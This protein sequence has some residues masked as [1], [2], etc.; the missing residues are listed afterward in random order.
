MSPVP[1]PDR[2]QIRN[3]TERVYLAEQAEIAW[4]EMGQSVQGPKQSLVRAGSPDVRPTS[5]AGHRRFSLHRRLPDGC[6]VFGIAVWV[7]PRTSRDRVVDR[8]RIAGARAI[9]FGAREDRIAD[10]NAGNVTDRTCSMSFLQRII[11]EAL[12]P[13][14]NGP[15]P[16]RPSQRCRSHAQRPLPR[17]LR[18]RR[19]DDVVVE[20]SQSIAAA[21]VGAVCGNNTS[22]DD[23][24][25]VEGARHE[26]SSVWFAL[27][28]GGG[29]Q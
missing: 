25:K 15:H 1:L 2:H 14:S 24:L 4:S 8:D 19:D 7:H 9:G 12:T 10:G 27:W 26:T 16:M 13:Q 3:R 17:N 29:M 11:R 20:P 5:S 6:D 21:A 23:L 18:K 22:A 28:R